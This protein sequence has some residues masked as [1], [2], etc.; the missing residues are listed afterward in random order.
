[1]PSSLRFSD[2]GQAYLQLCKR[3][4]ELD[5][6]DR[7]ARLDGFAVDYAYNSGKIENDAITLHDTREVF[8]RGGVSAFTGD[9]RTLFEIENLRVS[10]NWMLERLSAPDP[11]FSF[12]VQELLAC[13]RVLTQGTYDERR[14]SLGERPGEYKHHAYEVADGVGYEPEEVP[15]AI[16]ELL[17]EVREARAKPSDA[18]GSLTIAAY[19]HAAL[20]DI[21]PFA[22]GNG[23]LARQLANMQLLSTNL[24]PVLVPQEDRMAYYGALDAFHFE[25]DLLPFEEFLVAESL[26]VWARLLD[27]KR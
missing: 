7:S 21:H 17:A 16:E 20:V 23:R 22:D 5:T 4:K 8:E 18:L 9:V 15:E 1:M 26:R 25:D 24:P 13:H 14:W 3:W 27:R 11:G 12:D 19:L 6:N 10:W 2:L